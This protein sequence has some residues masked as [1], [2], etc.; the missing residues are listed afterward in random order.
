VTIRCGESSIIP[1]FKSKLGA[2]KCLYFNYKEYD[3]NLMRSLFIKN[4]TDYVFINGTT[5]I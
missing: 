2:K 5:S 3:L 1:I 4:S